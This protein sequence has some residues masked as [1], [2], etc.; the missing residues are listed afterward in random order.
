MSE[1]WR[2]WWSLPLLQAGP[3]QPSV[4]YCTTSTSKIIKVI[5]ST[6]TFAGCAMAYVVKLPACRCSGTGS[7]PGQF[8][9]DLWWT[10]WHWDR[11]FFEYWTG[12]SL[13]ISVLHSHSVS[14]TYSS[15]I[16][17]PSN[18]YKHRIVH[19]NTTNIT[20]SSSSPLWSSVFPPVWDGLRE[21]C[22]Y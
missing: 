11:P 15:L 14:A 20:L 10:K 12:S 8:L 22:F 9:Q 4:L 3:W 5:N 16:Y 13:S 21:T 17:K 2:S 19:L 6:K 7:I 1:R 18:W